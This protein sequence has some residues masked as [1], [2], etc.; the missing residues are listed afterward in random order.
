MK[1]ISRW[2]ACLII[3][4]F[5]F[6][7]LA[8]VAYAQVDLPHSFYGTLKINGADAPVVTVVTVEYAGVQC[9][10]YTTTE[11]GK[12]G[13]LATK[14]YLAVKGDIH[15]GDTI[16]FYVNGVDTNQMASFVP[17]GWPTELNLTVTIV[18]PA[19]PV[20]GGT[21]AAP[22]T[23]DTNLF[24]EVADFRISDDGEILTTIEA[25]S[26]DGMLTI[27][28]PAGTIALDKDGDPLD[29]VEASVDETPPDP[30]E[31]ANVIGLAYDF[32]PDGAT[33]DPAITL[34]YS[35]DPAD[36]PEGVAEEDLVL[37]Y[38]DEAAGEW[39]ALDC[40][41]DTENNTVTASVPHFTTFAIIGAVT[42]L[43]PPPPP[44]APAAFSLSNLTVKP[45]EVEPEQAVTIT[46]SVANTGGTEGSYTV[47][48]KLKGV[49]EAEKSITVAAGSSQIVTFSVTRKEA[50]SYSVVVDG[51]SSSFAVVVPPA[52]PAPPPVK[53]PVVP[54]PV[55]PKAINWPVLGGIIA[56][57]IVVGLLIFFL[58]RRKAA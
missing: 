11:A 38:Y 39:V 36:I 10:S 55:V 46:V 2:L 41:V 6:A 28:L 57:V 20:G 24:G 58:A 14:D 45:A 30:P 37:A 53:P 13:N 23:I 17:G 44:P 12:Y 3:S 33:F 29:S 9:G 49:K 32:G 35:Y 18:V 27:T 15:A 47:A 50:G 7:F 54:S 21:R 40:V 5:F 48:L 42:L 26:E 16:N 51:L 56:G 52:P 43:P 1:T 8:P 34:E 25:T 31:E 4:A 19:P 22:P